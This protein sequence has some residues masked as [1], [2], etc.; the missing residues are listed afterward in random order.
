ML[1]NENSFTVLEEKIKMYNLVK[2]NMFKMQ[3]ITPLNES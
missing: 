3:E 1:K 2:T